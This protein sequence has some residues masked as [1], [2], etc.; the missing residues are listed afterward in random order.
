MVFSETV[1]WVQFYV[2]K[3]VFVRYGEL[4]FVKCGQVYIKQAGTVIKEMVGL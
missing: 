4:T 3:N 2:N 1:N